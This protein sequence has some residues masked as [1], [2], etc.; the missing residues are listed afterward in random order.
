MTNRLHLLFEQLDLATEHALAAAEARA[1][2]R[3]H[4]PPVPGE[5]AAAGSF[6]TC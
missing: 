4:T 2:P 3:A 1:G 6:T 5:W